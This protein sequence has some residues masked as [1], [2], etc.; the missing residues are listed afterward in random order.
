MRRGQP[1]VF[2]LR[3]QQEQLKLLIS[4]SV[5]EPKLRLI[6]QQAEPPGELVANR[7]KRKQQA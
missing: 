2:W 7:S 1:V 6:L 5:D 4:D 3:L